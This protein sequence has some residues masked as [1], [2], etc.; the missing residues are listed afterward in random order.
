M[1][2]RDSQV[3]N[4][5]IPNLLTAGEFA[6]LACT[7][8]RT[9]LWYAQKGILKPIQVNEEG[10]RFYEPGQII[11]FQV[12]LLLRKLGFSLEE[13]KAYLA[14][15]KSLKELFE[16]KKQL[17][18][19]EIKRLQRSLIDIQTYYHNFEKNKVLVNP[20]VKRVKPFEI[21]YLEKEGPYA[22]IGSYCEELLAYFKQ[23]SQK[24]ITLAVFFGEGY[25]PKK[26]QMWI[27]VIKTS[28]MSLTEEGKK[29]IKNAIVPGYKALS[30]T[31]LGSGAILSLFWKELE[32][33]A[34]KK[35]YIVDKSLPFADLEFYHLAPKAN[36]EEGII[37][38]I[39]MPI[40]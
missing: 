17:V 22:K 4:E 28:K 11:D 33:Y 36:T 18:E 15:N 20:T 34:Q 5:M 3:P 26:H 32:K 14:K 13:I 19:K 24:L 21:Y 16:L 38:E 12:I 8:K 29:I 27:G 25:R 2:L 40:R 39:N 35:G 6:H 9:V 1:T 31:H 23:K 37:F 7:T 30:Q 10:Y